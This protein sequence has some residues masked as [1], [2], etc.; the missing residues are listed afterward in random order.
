MPDPETKEQLTILRTEFKIFCKNHDI[1]E[2]ERKQR[3]NAI[4]T[5]M[6]EIKQH[7]Y[8]LPCKVH[9]SR[10][11]TQKWMVGFLVLAVLGGAIRMFMSS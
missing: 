2:S 6:D 10:I 7:L 8:G 5:I 1:G 11:D 3:V 9:K 4:F